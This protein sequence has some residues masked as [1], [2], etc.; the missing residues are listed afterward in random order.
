MKSRALQQ[1][2]S[3]PRKQGWT[4]KERAERRERRRREPGLPGYRPAEIFAPI[5]GDPIEHLEQTRLA[6]IAEIEA[7]AKASPHVADRAAILLKLLKFTSL[8]RVR[9]DV[10]AQLGKLTPEADLRSLTDDQ[11]AAIMRGEAPAL[12]APTDDE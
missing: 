4:S 6:Y 1:Q 7:C 12:P 10:T 9:V 5:A 11:L 2:N 8:G 3:K